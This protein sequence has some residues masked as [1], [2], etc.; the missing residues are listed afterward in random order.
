[1][2][3]TMKYNSLLGILL[4][5]GLAACHTAG[6]EAAA[7]ASETEGAEA[8]IALSD[9][10]IRLAG[11]EL[12]LP[13]ARSVANYVE[14]SG[15]ID[16]PPSN[17]RS[18]HSPVMGFVQQVKHLPGEY[19]RRGE[20]LTALAHPELIRLQRTFL[21]SAGRLAFLKLDKDRKSELAAA[22]AAS[23]KAYEQAVSDYEVEKA[24]SEGLKAELKL[25]GINTDELEKTG[26]IQ[27]SIRLYAPVN[28]YITK[29][30]ANP[31]KLVEPNELLYEL[32]DNSHL[33]LELQVYA[34]DLAYIKEG[35]VVLAQVPGTEEVM[36]G[37]VHL[38]GKAIDPENKT[39]GL[40]VHLDQE[41]QGLAIGTYLQARIRVDAAE[42]QAVPEEA[43][44]R[45]GGQAFVFI[46]DSSGF[47]KHPVEVGRTEDG[48]VEVRGLDLAEGQQLALKGAYYI[49]GME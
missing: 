16:V 10:Q 42:V 49:N 39:V 24:H 22:D 47:K 44:V 27:E 12:G 20:L 2:Y 43:V 32:V 46:K 13:S 7:E 11:I 15:L 26:Q 6:E 1:M 3:N 34:K 29:M 35:Q 31:G 48:F 4:I 40:H 28:G 36:K 9:E 17:L 18:V 38:I 37:E 33:H 25:I 5:F 45:N 21:E 30:Q 14:C 23:R 41:P 19:V 8:T